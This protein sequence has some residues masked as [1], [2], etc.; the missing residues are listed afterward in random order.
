MTE[1]QELIERLKHGKHDQSTHGRRRGGGG[2]GASGGVGGSNKYVGAKGISRPSTLATEEQYQKYREEIEKHGDASVQRAKKLVDEIQQITR[3]Q[4]TM[5]IDARSRSGV[6]NQREKLKQE[7]LGIH[8][9][10]SQLR[11][12]LLKKIDA[13]PRRN[14]ADRNNHVRAVRDIEAWQYQIRK[15]VPETSTEYNWRQDT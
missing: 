7:L 10:F 12:G 3:Q 1:L 11:S 8:D 13:L 6:D 4:Q 2:G 5:T 9:S 15:L 14:N